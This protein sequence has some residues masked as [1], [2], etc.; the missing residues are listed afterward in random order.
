[1]L[2]V[3]VFSMGVSGAAL[4]TVIA[5]FM[6]MLGSILYGIW[7]NPYLKIE[8]EFFNP[9]RYLC[10]KCFGLGIPLA[11]QSVLFAVSGVGVQSIVNQYGAVVMAAYTVYGRV[12][13]FLQ[14]PFGCLSVS[15]SMFASQNAGA[16]KF[17]GIRQGVISCVRMAVIYG[18][19][20]IV[21]LQ[22]FGRSIVGMFVETEEVIQ[23]GAKGLCIVSWL[24]AIIGIK[25]TMNATLN[26][27]A[28]TAF[29]MWNGLIEV[30]GRVLFTL[31]LTRIPGIGLWGIWYA[32]ALTCILGA[33]I[34]TIRFGKERWKE[35]VIGGEYNGI[36]T[37]N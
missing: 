1:M 32:S 2:F 28:D 4:A 19:I 21:A 33:A 12:E 8:K 25:Y 6:A 37:G 9:D 13:Y 11:L 18:I 15:V 20:V 10:R 27:V 24:Y 7:K 29:T 35:K 31:V 16:G 26:G 22:V 30:L 3:A 5:Q 34:G 17:E 36:C 14:Q 23:I